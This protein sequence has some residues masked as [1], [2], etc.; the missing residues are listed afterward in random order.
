MKLRY[1]IEL[2]QVVCVA[3][4]KITLNKP[5]RDKEK[6]PPINFMFVMVKSSGC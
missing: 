4:I 2:E 6:P 5:R 1:N 3:N